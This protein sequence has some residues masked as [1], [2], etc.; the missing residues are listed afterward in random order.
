[1]VAGQPAACDFCVRKKHLR[2]L[3]LLSPGWFV[4]GETL[5]DSELEDVRRLRELRVERPRV[6]LID[7]AIERNFPG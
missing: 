3:H 6:S 4:W 7:L 1:M 5:S 2:G